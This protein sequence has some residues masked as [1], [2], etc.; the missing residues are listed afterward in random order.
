MPENQQPQGS[1]ARGPHTPQHTGAEHNNPACISWTHCGVT[2]HPTLAGLSFLPSHPPLTAVHS[3]C[4]CHV[5]Q[6]RPPCL[7]LGADRKGSGLYLHSRCQAHDG[8]V[9]QL[10][11]LSCAQF[12]QALLVG[13]SVPPTTRIK[14]Q[15]KMSTYFMDSALQFPKPNLLIRHCHY[16]A[17]FSLSSHLTPLLLPKMRLHLAH[18]SPLKLQAGMNR[19]T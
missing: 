4:D 15:N 13:C 12:W 18:T 3:G 2:G 1:T 6:E 9:L 10:V 7:R 11:L 17:L 16:T 14:T 8:Q 19:V 5:L